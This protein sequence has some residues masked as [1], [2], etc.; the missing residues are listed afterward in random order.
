MFENSEI[1]QFSRNPA[2]PEHPGNGKINQVRGIHKMKKDST[3]FD[4]SFKDIIFRTI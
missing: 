1:E 3:A 2:I 4:T